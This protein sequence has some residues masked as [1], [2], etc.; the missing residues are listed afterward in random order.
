MDIDLISSDRRTTVIFYQ[1]LTAGMTRVSR[2]VLWNSIQD[3]WNRIINNQF[4]VELSSGKLPRSRFSNYIRQDFLYLSDFRRAL[5]LTGLSSG[6]DEI[7][8]LFLRHAANSIQVEK[9]LHTEFLAG[10][11]PTK[12]E[13]SPENKAYCQF[14]AYHTSSGSF[15]RA[16]ASILACYWIY[17][18]V[19]KSL[20]RNLPD[21]AEYARWIST[22]S[23]EGSYSESVN[24]VLSLCESL[25]LS[26]NDY[27]DFISIFREGCDH[28]YDFWNSA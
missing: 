9:A 7:L 21:N 23:M 1:R 26:K 19:G 10:Q 2:N 13:K 12:S 8:D 17:L 20:S 28:E 5:L 11:V 16:L 25:E 18:E 24:E 14:L 22:Y 6:S 27:E 3:I 4:I 15:H